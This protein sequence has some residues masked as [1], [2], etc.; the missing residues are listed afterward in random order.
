MPDLRPTRD[1][2]KV[3]IRFLDSY[4]GEKDKWHTAALGL[5]AEIGALTLGREILDEIQKA[6]FNVY[7]QPAV[8]QGNQCA[9]ANKNCFIT[10]RQALMGGSSYSLSTELK[11]ATDRAKRAGMNIE[12]IA[13][14]LVFGMSAM[15]VET[16]RNVEKPIPGG[17]TLRKRDGYER[18]G[19]ARWK[20]AKM[21]EEKMLTLLKGLLDGSMGNAD[22]ANYQMMDGRSLAENLVRIFY[23]PYAGGS[24]M[25]VDAGAGCEATISFDPFKED[26]CWNDVMVKRPPAVG[27][28]HEL[29]HAWRNVRG[30]RY[31]PD[32][33]KRANAPTPDD[34]VMTTGFPPYNYEKFSE[35]LIRA[36]WSPAALDMRTAY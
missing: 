25:L 9:A 2:D 7:I 15:T 18:A 14:R 31:F 3:I 10:L 21:T 22:L 1:H 27:L 5:L 32:K 11:K 23:Q 28:A 17:G 12:S 26:S 34:E 29:I 8:A 30:L 6:G 20:D 16:S 35:N 19:V 36:G 33:E 24:G 4:R 13:K